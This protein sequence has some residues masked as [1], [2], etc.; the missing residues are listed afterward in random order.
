MA[1]FARNLI[2]ALSL[3]FVLVAADRAKDKDDVDRPDPP[4]ERRLET[5]RKTVL[6]MFQDDFDQAATPAQKRKLARELLDAPRIKDDL[7]VRC[8]LL[9]AAKE[10]AIAAGQT[11]L[12]IEAID[13]M[14]EYFHVDPIDMKIATLEQLSKKTRDAAGL[15]EIA[16]AALTVSKAASKANRFD[17]A[18]RIAMVALVAARKSHSMQLIEQC[19][20]TLLEITAAKKKAKP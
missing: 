7:D 14:A 13:L 3:S 2:A 15:R 11:G 1:T 20:T 5:A 17:D 10:Q 12:S 8:A 19:N 9:T 16:T 18:E 4:T 6:K